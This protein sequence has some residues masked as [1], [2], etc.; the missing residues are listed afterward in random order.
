MKNTVELHRLFIIYSKTKTSNIEE[1]RSI[2][3]RE[4]IYENKNELKIR[5]IQ[6]TPSITDVEDLVP[7][8]SKNDYIC[9]I[10]LIADLVFKASN[11]PCGKEQEKLDKVISYLQSHIKSSRKDD[12]YRLSKQVKTNITEREYSKLII[13]CE[14]FNYSSVSHY[15]RD[16]IFNRVEV[17]PKSSSNFNNHFNVS[18]NIS[19][20]L[21]EISSQ[22]DCIEH[23]INNKEAARK[24]ANKVSELKRENDLTRNLVI[25]HHNR[26]TATIIALRHLSSENIKKLAEEKLVKEREA[27]R[28]I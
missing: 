15:L 21:S 14:H 16:L 8:M 23:I 26:Q 13:A 11:N 6:L 22:D 17:L 3:D 4:T 5:L 24:F 10:N 27:K 19:Y 20:Y 1:L 25:D 9:M 12:R 2:L 18:K 28:D 7:Q